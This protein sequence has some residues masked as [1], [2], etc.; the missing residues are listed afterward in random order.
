[1]ENGED[2]VFNQALM[3]FLLAISGKSFRE[4][5]GIRYSYIS[6]TQG[7]AK[8]VQQAAKLPDSSLTKPYP[9][10][11]PIPSSEVSYDAVIFDTYDYF[12]QVISYSLSDVFSAAFKIHLNLTSDYPS[13]KII[14]LLKFGTNN[15]DHI[16]LMRYGF[17]PEIVSEIMPYI[18][19]INEQNI[20][21]HETI[22]TAPEYL[23]DI[24]KWYL[25]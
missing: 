18:R 13:N 9:L 16:L 8:F 23:K 12:D 4:I 22:N 17:S 25:P 1:M 10:F 5:S 11:K 7:N 6:R 15:I 24:S 19:F 2:A 20:I 21:F 14:E 3:I